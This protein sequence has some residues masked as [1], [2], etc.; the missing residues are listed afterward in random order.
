MNKCAERSLEDS[1]RGPAEPKKSRKPLEMLGMRMAKASNRE[2]PANTIIETKSIQ[3][4]T[5]GLV[6][7]RAA[8][9]DCSLF[10]ERPIDGGF[11]G[12]FTR[13]IWDLRNR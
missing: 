3:R 10:L 1:A 4:R 6:W 13:K 12:L 5:V 8:N 11:S 2:N 9:G 7:L